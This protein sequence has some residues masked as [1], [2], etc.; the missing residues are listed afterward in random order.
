MMVHHL[1]A[2]IHEPHHLLAHLRCIPQSFC[3]ILARFRTAKDQH[4]VR[5]VTPTEQRPESKVQYHTES[6]HKHQYKDSIDQDPGKSR[7][8]DVVASQGSTGGNLAH[9]L[10]AK[11]SDNNQDN[12]HKNGPQNPQDLQG[13]RLQKPCAVQP[14]EGKRQGFCFTTAI[15]TFGGK[16]GSEHLLADADF[17][18]TLN[19]F[20][21]T[22]HH[23]LA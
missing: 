8:V 21:G 4:L 9:K 10:R 2:F 3:N 22:V 17:R 13:S 12:T 16:A 14:C 23:S 11:Q 19:S 6:S 5:P 1:V 7:T 18:E 15:E 20:T